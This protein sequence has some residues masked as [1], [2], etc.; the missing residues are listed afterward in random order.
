MFSQPSKEDSATTRRGDYRP[1]A[2]ETQNRISRIIVGI[3][4][5]LGIALLATATGYAAIRNFDDPRPPRIASLAPTK[6]AIPAAEAGS[7]DSGDFDL[8]KGKMFYAQAC[9]SCHGQRG[10]GMPHQG[11]SLR[12]SKF[13]AT[14]SDRALAAF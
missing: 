4:I 5:V 12:E 7:I 6:I 14:T 3:E 1:P 11:V 13:V 10:Q 8:A 9:T 2:P